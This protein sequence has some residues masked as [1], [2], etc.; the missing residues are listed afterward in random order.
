SLLSPG[1][2]LSFAPAV[3]SAPAALAAD[4]QHAG[5]LRPLLP[6]ALPV[7]GARVSRPIQEPGD[8]SGALLAELRPLPR[9]QSGRS[10]PGAGRLAV[11]L[12]ELPRLCPGCERSLAGVQSLVRTMVT[13]P[14]PATGALAGVCARIGSAGR[15][16]PGRRLAIGE[17]EFRRRLH[18]PESRA[19]PR[20]AG[21]PC[22]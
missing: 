19:V 13:G 21:R 3:G 4:G 16:D 6:E 7:C 20:G 15:S 10:E 12:V 8:R 1:Q 11:P 17:P 2:P 9:A 14:D 18:R 22:G 5:C